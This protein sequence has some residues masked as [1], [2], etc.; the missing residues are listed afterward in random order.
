MDD[1]DAGRDLLP[2]ISPQT[3]EWSRAKGIDIILLGEISELKL[4]Q[5]CA[6]LFGSEAHNWNIRRIVCIPA[7]NTACINSIPFTP[8]A[9]S[10]VGYPDS[11]TFYSIKDFHHG[12]P[13]A[14]PVCLGVSNGRIMKKNNSGSGAGVMLH[15]DEN[16]FSMLEL[17]HLQRSGVPPFFALEQTEMLLPRKKKTE[18]PLHNIRVAIRFVEMKELACHLIGGLAVCPRHHRRKWYHQ[19]H[20]SHIPCSRRKW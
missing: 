18:M 4:Q 6:K 7:E 13:S 20:I 9:T 11:P 14:R 12:S 5:L 19:N 3:K 8:P 1:A 10:S 17:R 15:S 16:I 2:G